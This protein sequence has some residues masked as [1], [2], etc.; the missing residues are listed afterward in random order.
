MRAGVSLS[1]NRDNAPTR[2]PSDFMEAPSPGQPPTAL[3]L[4]GTI[5]MGCMTLGGVA[6]AH[7]YRS[8]RIRT[9]MLTNVD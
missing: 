2:A 8:H 9:Q 1:L 3:A 6:L 4:T 7:P 5:V